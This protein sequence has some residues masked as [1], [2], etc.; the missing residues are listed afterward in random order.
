M[1][2]VHHR[3]PLSNTTFEEFLTSAKVQK[4]DEDLDL[5]LTMVIILP[6]SLI[7][8]CVSIKT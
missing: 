3:K 8:I 7:E 2:N 6:A 4:T 1:A 5:L